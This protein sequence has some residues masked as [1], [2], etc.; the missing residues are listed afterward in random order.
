[1]LLRI[2]AVLGLVLINAFFVAAEF[3][4]VRSRK[5]RLEAM[6]RTGDGLARVALKAT[7]NLSAALSASQLGVTLTSLLL[8]WIA[9]SLLVEALA[10]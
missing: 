7:K 8:G 1:M 2:A 5:T 6:A 10:E 9:E 3:A 4:L